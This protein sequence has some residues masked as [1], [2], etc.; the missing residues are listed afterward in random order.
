MDGTWLFESMMYIKD[1]IVAVWVSLHLK[2]SVARLFQDPH[3]G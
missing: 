2:S 1:T 3:I